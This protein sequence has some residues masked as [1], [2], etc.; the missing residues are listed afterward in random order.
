MII[1]IKPMSVNAVWQGKR[2]KTPA[3]KKY[4]RDCAKLLTQV[5]VPQGDFC[6]VLEF[7]V[8]NNAFDYDNGI[9]PFQDILQKRYDF[10]DKRITKALIT[11][12]VV[13][14][15][16]EYISFEFFKD[17]AIAAINGS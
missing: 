13:P 5:T 11:K 10:D 6:L 15:G 14:K 3:Y 7:G 16:K 9:K 2:F 12:V 4:E 1:P 17:L 8:S